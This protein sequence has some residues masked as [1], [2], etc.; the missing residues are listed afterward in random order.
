M[1]DP[2]PALTP[3][4]GARPLF[5]L[6][7]SVPP[8]RDIG[9]P[10]GAGLRVATVAG[11]AFAGERL[12]GT[13]EGGSDWQT[14]RSDGAIAIDARILLRTDEDEP[15]GLTYRGLRHGPPDVMA[16]LSGGEDVDPA[17]YYFR[18]LCTF[19]TSAPRLEWLNR[20]LAVGTG[21]RLPEGPVYSVVELG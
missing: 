16:R 8:L 20:A 10:A 19:A 21:R 18:I 9:G 14:L 13:V 4:L 15:V 5:E 1:T 3:L 6:R 12:R 17:S 11:G 2:D 7:L